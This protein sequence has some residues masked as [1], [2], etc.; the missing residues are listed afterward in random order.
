MCH[1]WNVNILCPNTYTKN[2]FYTNIHVQK[3][4]YIWILKKALFAK[5]KNWKPLML[6]KKLGHKHTMKIYIVFFNEVDL[7]VLTKIFKTY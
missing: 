1:I 3:Y 6:K 4:V 5:L 2:L 7:Y